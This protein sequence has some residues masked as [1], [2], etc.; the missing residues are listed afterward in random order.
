MFFVSSGGSQTSSSEGTTGSTSAS[1]GTQAGA[2]T[3]TTNTAPGPSPTMGQFVFP[4][5]PPPPLQPGSNVP[6]FCPPFPF[7]PFSKYPYLF[8]FENIHR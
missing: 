6:I 3:S 1:P 4:P 8:Y 5:P 2:S 7:M